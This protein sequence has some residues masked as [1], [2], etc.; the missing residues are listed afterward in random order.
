MNQ[1]PLNQPPPSSQSPSD[2][3]PSPLPI[4]SPPPWKRPRWLIP[5]IVAAVALF[6]VMQIIVAI[7]TFRHNWPQIGLF[8]RHIT[9]THVPL[10]VGSSGMMKNRTNQDVYVMIVDIAGNN[11][12]V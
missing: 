7:F 9:S 12:D 10:I 1:R 2:V 6:A 5:L 3:P 11:H 4:I 8:S